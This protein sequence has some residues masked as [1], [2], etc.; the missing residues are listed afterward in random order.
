MV[1]N[2][3]WRVTCDIPADTTYVNGFVNNDT[4]NYIQ[5][6]SDGE[7]QAVNASIKLTPNTNN[8]INAQN[9]NSPLDGEYDGTAFTYTMAKDGNDIIVTIL[10]LEGNICLTDRNLQ[11]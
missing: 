1:A 9:L 4:D 6:T 11:L 7:T 5:V 2:Q 10:S 8:V 3:F